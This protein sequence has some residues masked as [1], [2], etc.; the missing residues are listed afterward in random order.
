MSDNLK[1]YRAIKAG[2]KQLYPREVQGHLAQHLNVLA[3]LI[4]GIV[5][6][7]NSQ[8]PAIASK[9]PGLT[10]PASR[11]KSCSRWINDEQNDYDTYFLPFV[12]DLL[13]QLA[14][15]TLVLIMDSSEV[16]RKCLTLMISVVYQGRA[17]PIAWVVYKGNKGHLPEGT[18]VALLES[19]LEL[20]PPDSDVVFLGDGEFDGT[21]LLETIQHAG[22]HYVCRTAQNA[23]LYGE[24]EVLTFGEVGLQRGQQFALPQVRFTHQHYGPLLAIA[25]WDQ[26]QSEP[27]Y[28]VSNFELMDEA[29]YWYAKRFRIE[30]FF[31]DQKSRGFNLHKSHLSDPM[32]LSRLMLATCLAYIWVVYL[33][34]IAIADGW[35][36]FLHRA[37][38]CDLSL[39]QLGLRLLEHFVES[40][41]DIPVA[42]QI[43]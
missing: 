4:S 37:D 13:N 18:H 22:A 23:K 31:S 10:Q 40:K 11:A 27:I 15:V 25:W 7:R 39:F 43:V 20:L 14:Q 35:Q 41:A 34:M 19:V 42:F 36:R 8:L 38:R 5:G 26:S 24:D 6:S 33:G 1:R 30:T 16:G 21:N 28:L 29:C 2:L 12:H 3:G 17:L 9:M 32:R